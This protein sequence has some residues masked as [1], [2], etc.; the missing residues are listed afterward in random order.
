MGK[1]KVSSNFSHPIFLQI[2]MDLLLNHDICT[3][4]QTGEAAGDDDNECYSEAEDECTEM[5]DNCE[6]V[7]SSDVS[8]DN[9]H[10][11]YA[12]AIGQ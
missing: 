11:Q 10:A 5:D 6:S 12:A 2:C 4:A 3:Q 8:D 9:Q 1:R 7:H